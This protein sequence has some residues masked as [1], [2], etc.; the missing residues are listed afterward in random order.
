MTYWTV[1]VKRGALRELTGDDVFP[2]EVEMIKTAA[3]LLNKAYGNVHL[4]TDDEGRAKLG[5]IEWST[6]DTSLNDLPKEYCSTWSLGKIKSYNIISQR[7]EP[8][9]HVD[10]DFFI[11]QRLPKDIEEKPIIFEAKEPAGRQHNYVTAAFKNYCRFKHFTAPGQKCIRDDSPENN[12]DEG[13][14]VD[15]AFSCG[16]VGGTDLDYFFNYSESSLRTVL[17]PLNKPFFT[18]DLPTRK[19]YHPNLTEHSPAVLAEQYYAALVAKAMNRTPSFLD[20]AKQKITNNIHEWLNINAPHVENNF[21]YLHLRGFF[22]IYFEQ[23]FH[24]K[25]YKP[26]HPFDSTL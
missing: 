9:L 8:F 16:V 17:D 24:H 14:L 12:F 3:D 15:H 7:G 19:R 2:R 13:I 11:S 21:K 10:G 25:I 4:I 5:S 26:G 6:V 23:I 20:A 22:K 18:S 1:P